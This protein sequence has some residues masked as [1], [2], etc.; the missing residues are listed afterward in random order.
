MKPS[1]RKKFNRNGFQM[2]SKQA[3]SRSKAFEYIILCLMISVAATSIVWSLSIHVL[4]GDFYNGFIG[5]KLVFRERDLT[6]METIEKNIWSHDLER[7]FNKTYT[8]EALDEIKADALVMP[9]LK[10]D[11]PSTRKPKVHKISHVFQMTN[12]QVPDTPVISKD[13]AN[14]DNDDEMEDES[15]KRVPKQFNI[16]EDR[17]FL[18]R[19]TIDIHQTRWHHGVAVKFIYSF[20]F[21]SEIIAIIWTAMCFIFQSG[22][23][24]TWGLPKPWRIV[25]PS[26]MMFT[27]MTVANLSYLILANGFLKSFCT[28]LR[29]NLSN[30][31]AI[32]CGDAMAILRPV[33]RTQTLSHNMYLILFRVSYTIAMILWILALLI[34]VVRFLL[35]IDFQLVDVETNYDREMREAQLKEQEFVDVILNSPKISKLQTLSV[36]NERPKSEE[37]FQSAKSHLSEV[38]TP[39]LESLPAVNE[40][41]RT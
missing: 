12:S 2:L 35:A 41:K 14:E 24:K 37:D 27:I 18:S 11:E 1:R 26:I 36:K 21:F 20:P 32:S 25:I 29:E 40:D 5:A 16:E 10:D 7:I 9:K 22:V 19:M 13:I 39:L 4:S 6:Q 28:E 17:R 33:I 8:I 30:P 31:D 3:Q 23:K 15:T 34:M 38:A